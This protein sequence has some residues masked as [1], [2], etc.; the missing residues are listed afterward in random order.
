MQMKTCILYVVEYHHQVLDVWRDQQAT[1]LQVTH[2]DA[3]CDMRG[4]YM[5][6]KAQ[7]AFPMIGAE[8]RLD[9]GN[10]L[11]HAILDGR[12]S[13]LE[14]VYSEPGGRL[15]DV[16]TIKYESD[17]TAFPYRLLKRL[18]HTK[19]IP[20][21]YREL[22]IS[23]W[24]AESDAAQCLDID[25]D[26]LA[27]ELFSVDSIPGRVQEFMKK[28]M[29]RIPNQIFVCYSPDYSHPSREI[30]QAFIDDLAKKYHAQV[31]RI[32]SKDGS[33][34][35]KPFYR[36]YLPAG[37]FQFARSAYYQGWFF[38]KRLGIY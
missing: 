22:K 20:L 25:W 29:K 7:V 19:G 27:S 21:P 14:W 15:Y 11:T 2:I 28:E 17:L 23:E 1:N 16:G 3:H 13:R 12:I 4:L 10:Y 6:R 33:L 26:A 9:P 5:D 24:I 37:L 31:V 38:L 35:E 30:F 18:R 32:P 36:R 8:S 34:N